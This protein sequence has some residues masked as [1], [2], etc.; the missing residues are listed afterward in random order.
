MVALL[1]HGS[2]WNQVGEK[3]KSEIFDDPGLAAALPKDVV[4]ATVDLK[5]N[6]SAGERKRLEGA[7]K[8]PTVKVKTYPAI[9]VMD[10]VGRAIAVVQPV[11]QFKTA[12]DLAAALTTWHQ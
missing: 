11:A 4:L 12:N 3:F 10:G 8:Y 2:D 9:I 5:E 1:L 7:D 6:P